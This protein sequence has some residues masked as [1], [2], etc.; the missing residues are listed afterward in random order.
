MKIFLFVWLF[1]ALCVGATAQPRG[2][3]PL[4]PAFIHW[5]GNPSTAALDT[6]AHPGTVQLPCRVAYLGPYVVFVSG[7]G[8]VSVSSAAG[9][10]SNPVFAPTNPVDLADVPHCSSVYGD[11]IVFVSITDGYVQPKRYTV[12][13][14]S[15]ARKAFVR[16]YRSR[17]PV[18]ASY[19]ADG[20]HILV[21]AQGHQQTVPSAY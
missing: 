13:E 17:T 19:S 5:K 21:E 11:K 15:L 14:L 8:E 20:T 4:R 10:H 7:R 1:L 3:L 16:P 18:C 12:V 9:D 2:P 6:I